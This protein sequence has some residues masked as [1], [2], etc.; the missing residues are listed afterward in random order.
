MRGITVVNLLKKR[1][2][3]S[4][5]IWAGS[6]E[7]SNMG[8]LAYAVRR[9]QQR[10]STWAGSSVATLI[11]VSLCSEAWWKEL[12]EHCLGETGV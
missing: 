3:S 8:L 1:V 5:S 7:A 10:N 9:V 11:T 6:G 12:D 4:D 2:L